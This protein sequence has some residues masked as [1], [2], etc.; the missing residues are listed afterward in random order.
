[1]LF[2]K[3]DI[4]QTIPNIENFMSHIVAITSDFCVSLHQIAERICLITEQ[5]AE[6]V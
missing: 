5:K 6:K 2:P 3:S 1:M 4:K